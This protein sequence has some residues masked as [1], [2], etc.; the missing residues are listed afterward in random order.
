M[1]QTIENVFSW[2]FKK[3]CESTCLVANC[4]SSDN[5]ACYCIC[6]KLDAIRQLQDLYDGKELMYSSGAILYYPSE[7]DRKKAI[8]RMTDEER[9]F[10]GERKSKALDDI[11][12]IVE[13]LRKYK[14]NDE[15]SNA[16]ANTH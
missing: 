6:R 7:E 1:N 3:H 9:L 16:S 4:K 13:N 2:K 12:G 14:E 10:L 8:D 15:H 5:G 11:K